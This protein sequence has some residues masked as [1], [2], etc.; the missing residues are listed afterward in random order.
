MLGSEIEKINKSIVK[1]KY[2]SFKLL[3]KII[4]LLIA[5]MYI[6]IILII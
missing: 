4:V 5:Y 3:N 1:I 2:K 6:L